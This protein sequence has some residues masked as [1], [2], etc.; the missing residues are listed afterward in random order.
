[1]DDMGSGFEEVVK[2]VADLAL[3]SKFT[4]ILPKEKDFPLSKSKGWNKAFYEDKSYQA[5]KELNEIFE[6]W[7]QELATN[8]RAFAPLRTGKGITSGWVDGMI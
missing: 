5:L 4:E 3:L 7:Y 8:K 1:M 2:R 6:N